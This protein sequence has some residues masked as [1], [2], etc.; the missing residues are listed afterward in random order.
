M[1]IEQICCSAQKALTNQNYNTACF[2]KIALESAR[3]QECEQKI[4][5]SW[6]Q[7]VYNVTILLG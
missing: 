7:N 3:F 1:Y 6:Y 4:K 2:I 5:M